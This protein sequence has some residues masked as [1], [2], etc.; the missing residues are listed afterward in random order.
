MNKPKTIKIAGAGL[1]GSL[2][3]V[4]LGRRGYKVDIYEQRGDMRRQDVESGRSINLALSERGIFAL[5]MS[6]LM[7]K[8]E[9][10]LIPMRG[11]MLHDVSGALEFLPYGGRKHEVIYSVSRELLNGLMMTAAEIAPDVNVHFHQKCESVDFENNS[12]SMTDLNTGQTTKNKFEILIGVDGA[13]SRIRRNMI[14]LTE[15]ESTSEFLNHDYKELEIPPGDMGVHKIDREALHI[16][17]RGGYMLIA[18]PNLDGS[19]TVTLFMPKTGQNSFESLDNAEAVNRF[20]ERQFPDALELMPDLCADYFRNPQGLLGTLRC[21]P[22][23]FRDDVLILGDAAHAVVPFHGQGMIAGFEDCSELI[24]L[25]NKYDDDWATVLPEFDEIRRPNANAIA[26]MALENY[27]TMRDSVRDPKFQLKKELGFELERK[28]PNRFI[29][30]YSMVMF[31]RIPYAEV[32]ARGEI[33][34]DILNQLTRDTGT[35]DG[36][37]FELAG[38]LIEARLPKLN[39]ELEEST[40]E[41]SS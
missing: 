30:R 31:H 19:F 9:E 40:Q 10:L 11:R 22:W 21:R 26:D 14:P 20:F 33:Q 34:E 17:P 6:G 12:L 39:L 27:I 15:G 4:L 3:G 29:P 28:Y 41:S 2:L 1:V 13:G 5:K 24:R 8:V 38:R 18:L 16:W 37:D 25:L 32:F 7:D 23:H 36:V 35:V